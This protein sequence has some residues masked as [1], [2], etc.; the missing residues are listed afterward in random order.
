MSNKIGLLEERV[1]KLENRVN[2]PTIQQTQAMDIVQ[3]SL[4]NVEI[5]D[6]KIKGIQQSVDSLKREHEQ[7]NEKVKN[8]LNCLKHELKVL[9]NK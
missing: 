4:S 9:K 2:S 7:D 1:Q 6:Q 8:T 5:I 3:P